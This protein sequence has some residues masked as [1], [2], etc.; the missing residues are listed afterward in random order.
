MQAFN[1]N[2]NDAGLFGVYATAKASTHIFVEESDFFGGSRTVFYFL[3]YNTSQLLNRFLS[4]YV[5]SEHVCE[6]CHY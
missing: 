4:R 1:T 2:Y 6:L 3:N 5:V